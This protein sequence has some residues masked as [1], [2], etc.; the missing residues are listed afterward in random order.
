MFRESAR[1]HWTCNYQ[2]MQMARTFLVPQKFGTY[3]IKQ[4]REFRQEMDPMSSFFVL[5]VL[6]FFGIFLILP[7]TNIFL[8]AFIINGQFSLLY[9]E[10]LLN[11]PD[12]F[13]LD[14]SKIRNNLV[15]RDFQG[16]IHIGS[17]HWNTVMNTIFV[18]IGTTLLSTLIGI[19]LAYAISRHDF[20]GKR[21]VR[22]LVLVPLIIPPFVSGIGIQRI[23]FQRFS[24]FN[25]LFNPN[26]GNMT[27]V[28]LFTNPIIIEGL[29]AVIITQSLHFYTLVYLNV[30]AAL[31]NIDPTLEEQA[32][33]LGASQFKLFRTVTLPLA[34]PGIAAGSILTFILSIEDV[35]TP[36][37]FADTLPGNPPNQVSSLLTM[38]IFTNI[39]Q[40]TGDISGKALAMSIFLLIMALMGFMAIRKYVSLRRYAMLSKGGIL[41]PRI[42]PM[43]T[44]NVVLF[45]IFFIPF[46]FV[47]LTP[48]LGVLLL[49]FT[50]KQYWD[51]NDPLPKQLTL[52]NFFNDPRSVFVD[53]ELTKAVQ[54]TL[55]ISTLA[56]III[57]VL[58]I[59]AAYVL[60]RKKFPGK[61]VIDALV[62]MPIAVPGLV[63]GVGYFF[64]FAGMP[65]VFNPIRNPLNILVFS[66]AVRRFPF[67]VRAAYAGLQQTDVMLEEV[68]WNLGASKV[69]TL[70]RVTIPLIA[71]NVIAGSFISFVYST[72]EVS[73][74]ITL[75]GRG[76]GDNATIPTM[77]ADRIRDIAG[78]FELACALGF[79]LMSMQILVIVISEKILKNRADAMTGI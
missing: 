70:F 33:N 59:F 64:L 6:M 27:L 15:Y 18:A 57:I 44:R 17:F 30:S 35:G 10:Q 26:I 43:R 75:I 14:P 76:G 45:Y 66:F 29:L 3:L 62:T 13:S 51:I 42:S 71:L 16:A 63:L 36:I 23:L 72:A 79:I 28:P 4:A 32:E 52:D 69:S 50:R 31:V 53:S 55:V 39:V 9:F 73:T 38:K 61:S 60:E 78:G 19:I 41:N 8:S 2:V 47:A 77:I 20:P 54:N 48:H 25:I 67:T 74:S 11:D 5:T 12:F 21:I 34:M 24:V 46:I 65:D 56:V 49:A 22:V 68:S 7:L 58:G 40:I 37:V 1:H